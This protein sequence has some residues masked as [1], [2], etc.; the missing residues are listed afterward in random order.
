MFTPPMAEAPLRGVVI[1]EER[2]TL[3]V[4]ASEQD[5][6]RFA[7]SRGGAE[8]NVQAATLRVSMGGARDIY[9]DGAPPENPGVLRMDDFLYDR[10]GKPVARV[11]DVRVDV[12][13]IDVTSFG[14]VARNFV[15][16]LTH[17]RIQADGLAGVTVR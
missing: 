14:D 1:R 15:N 12:D 11:R 6:Q 17:V 10:E 16:G 8:V 9:A 7:R 4:Q 5:V 3:V 13:R 2:D